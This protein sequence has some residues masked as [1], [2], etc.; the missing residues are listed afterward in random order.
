M[1]AEP[2]WLRETGPATFR[3]LVRSEAGGTSVELLPRP[4]ERLIASLTRPAETPAPRRTGRADAV[5]D[6]AVYRAGR[7]RDRETVHYGEAARQVRFARGGF[8]WLGLHEPD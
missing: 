5:V 4:I 7:R 8:V 3:D 6:C 1:A 2:A